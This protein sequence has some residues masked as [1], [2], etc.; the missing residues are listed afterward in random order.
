MHTAQNAYDT[1]TQ[2]AS[3]TRKS[4]I[5]RKIQTGF[6]EVIKGGTYIRIGLG[7]I[8]YLLTNTNGVKGRGNRKTD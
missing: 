2:H 4:K 6:I 5:M 1:F 8:L 3:T 7:F